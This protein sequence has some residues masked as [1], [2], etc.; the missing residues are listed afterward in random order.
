M[1]ARLIKVAVVVLLWGARALAS[2]TLVLIDRSGS[3]KRYYESGL[4]RNIV[5]R[6]E[7]GSSAVEHPDLAMFDVKVVRIP[8]LDSPDFT[9]T[10]NDTYL[11]DALSEAVRDHKRV[12]VLTDN[13][14]D[15]A[16]S[17]DMTNFYKLLQS[18]RIR[19]IYLFPLRQQ[20]GSQGLL[21]YAISTES[22]PEALEREVAAFR[23]ATTDLQLS[24][25]PMKPL[26]ENVI[27]VEL[28]AKE[29]SF[30]FDEGQV[31]RFGSRVR[32][33]PKFP[34][35]YFEASQA[36]GGNLRSPFRES[37]CLVSEKSESSISP[38]MVQT[39]EIR[40]YQVTVNFGRVKL[41][42]SFRCIWQ[43]AFNRSHESQEI[44][45][46]IE[47]H[48][49]QANFRLADSFLTGFTAKTPSE[50]LE[51]GKIAG[52]QR[53]PEFLAPSETIVPVRIPAGISVSYPSWP[54]LVLI[55]LGALFVLLALLLLRALAAAISKAGAADIWAEDEHGV[56][57]PAELKKD[58]VWLARKM[59]GTKANQHFRPAPGIR[60]D[61]PAQLAS[62]LLPITVLFTNGSRIRFGVGKRPIASAA[63]MGARSSGPKAVILKKR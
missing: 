37:S 13:V 51:T 52:L 15:E 19:F 58:E 61:P 62:I 30:R 42:R 38:E 53:L 50:A 44:Q 16:G 6:I 21:I 9:F 47:I 63:G 14:Q 41:R 43:A 55:A 24:E 32:I 1:A 56:P 59:V 8:N 45:T 39:S 49:P 36:H 40:D 2:D 26:G 31:L 28:A 22:S 27:K 10:H 20:P 4:V 5:D 25:L 29:P 7:R 17:Q 60:L 18:D 57:V 11:T 46:P 54:A 12:W 3:M 23:S 34:H 33:G 48:V 35:L